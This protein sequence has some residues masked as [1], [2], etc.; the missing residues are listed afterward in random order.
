MRASSGKTF[1]Q[2][3]AARRPRLPKFDRRGSVLP[4]VALVTSVLIG[5]AGLAVDGA[6]LMLMHSKLQA[7][8][9]AAGLSAVARLNT[10]DI[11]NQVGKFTRA[12]FLDGYVGAEITML[13]PTL[14]ADETTLTVAATAT[15]DTTFMR[16]FGIDTM[17]TQVET[18]V[19]HAMGG[20]EL[21]M[22][23]DVTGSME[24]D[25]K[26]GS[27]KTASK[28]LLDILFGTEATVDKLYV[29]IVPFSQSVNIG[30]GRSSWLTSGSQGCVEARFNGRDL[31][32]D[33]PTVEKFI[34]Y[35]GGDCPAAVT[36]LTSTKATLISAINKLDPVGRTHIAFG[37]SW[38]WNMLSPRWRGA[39]GGTMG[40]NL[41]LAYGTTGMSKA[42]IIMTDGENTM[43]SGTAY[44][45]ISCTGSNP[46]TCSYDS[47]LNVTANGTP[48]WNKTATEV[49]TA[50]A[51][52][53]AEAVLDAKL[54]TI[55]NNMKNAGI[56]IYTVALGSPG[57]AIENRLKACAS[58]NAFYFD[59]PT[60][61]DLQTAFAK[62]GDSLSSLR[63][64]R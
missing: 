33:P 42:A 64:S 4:L 16:L 3:L 31:S 21:A 18:S 50:A 11:N 27:L 20:L 8:V 37:A 41:P 23:L 40:S 34:R 29:G 7:A 56:T 49:A 63:V 19:T 38:G 45:E 10:T 14:S 60:G 32:D 9:D 59:S 6:R 58:Q 15:A 2:R 25:D 26:I 22:I 61:A 13:T 39:W 28:A 52:T 62:I 46:A 12:N 47:R 5:C 54:T 1:R 55:C 53:A 36:P 51:N 48:S 44:G 57:T 30:T 17:T 24:T 43:T 35:T